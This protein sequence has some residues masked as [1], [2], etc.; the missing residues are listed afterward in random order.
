MKK[1]LLIS[2]CTIGLLALPA[3]AQTSTVTNTVSVEVP[4][5]VTTTTNIPNL[6][7]SVSISP[8]LSHSL[9]ELWDVTA[10]STNSAVVFGGGRGLT[11][12]KNFAFANYLYNLNQ[13]AG[14]LLGYDYLF[15]NAK[16]MGSS[17]NV[18]KGGFN[19]QASLYPLKR[20]GYTNFMV[21]PFAALVIATPVSGNQNNG[22]IGQIALTGIDWESPAI[23]F[24]WG[25]RAHL[26][27][28]YENRTGQGAWNG[29]YLGLHAAFSKGF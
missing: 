19:L 4:V 8:T 12:N 2:L 17:A 29:N 7:G 24:L 6:L 16:G 18:L 10:G 1:L 20:F 22:G 21:T 27:G 25:T 3:V 5:I 11:G 23:G 13:N 26:G 28:F 9:Q 14:L 15:S